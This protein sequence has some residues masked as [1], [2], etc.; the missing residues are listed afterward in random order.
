MLWIFHIEMIHPK[1][2]VIFIIY[3]VNEHEFGA[4]VVICYP[5]SLVFLV[6]SV[7]IV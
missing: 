7:K 5:F 1:F 6:I 3:D 2:I 4:G